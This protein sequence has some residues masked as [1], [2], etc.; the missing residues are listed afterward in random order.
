MKKIG[1]FIASEQ[2]GFFIAVA[3]QLE[4]LYGLT[5]TIFARDKYVTNLA[6]KILPSDS[7]V[8]II[9]L[10]MLL[11]KVEPSLVIKEA[12]RI[13]NRY[14][15]KLSMLLSADRA[16]GQ[17]YLSNV[18]KVPDIKR[19]SWP[20]RRKIRGI[21]EDFI[22]KEGILEGLDS[23]LQLYPNKVVSKICKNNNTHF[24]SFTYI[25]FGDRMFW[26]DDDF[27]T[28]SLYIKKLQENLK[29]TKKKPV[30][31]YCI[32]KAGDE[33]N[34]SAKYS[35]KLAIKTAFKI[36]LNDSKKII[37]GNNKKY[38][39]HYL[40]WLPSVFRRVSNY[41]YVKNNSITINDLTSYKIVFFTLHLEPEVALQSF[42][43]EFS[44]SMEAITWISKSL[45]VNYILVVKEQVASYG[46]R[47]RWYYRQ[48]MKIP[49]VVL[50][51]P[52]VHSWDWI[53]ASSIIA[54]I[55]GTIGQEAIH[56]ERPVLSF[57]KHQIINHLP[58]VYYVSNYIE[59]ALAI[60][61]IIN[62]STTKELYEK[63][64]SA[65]SNAQ[66]DSSISMPKFK[67][68]YRSNKFEET[69]ALEAIENLVSEYPEIL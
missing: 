61:K 57:G 8:K 4:K 17:G 37:R 53:K 67:N 10:S 12:E 38:S 21:V 33:I 3:Y 69:M 2:K 18:Q 11:D 58:T 60:D 5:V 7:L 36:I 14:Q 40:G 20:H 68:T 65:F 9:D 29:S 46:V 43:P 59:T 35:Y 49:N 13:E 15:V 66:F 39:Y 47:S 27:I 1:I 44:N 6:K 62:I 56:F 50:S 22:Q 55:T 51:H 25:K 31:N 26:S 42:S 16:L 24:F 30:L 54:T 23:V 45:P 48:L 52:D 34:K 28:G 41:N 19:A 64:K 63:S 32:D